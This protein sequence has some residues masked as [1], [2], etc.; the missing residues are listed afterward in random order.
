M[1]VETLR[2]VLCRRRL[3][4]VGRT[5][6]AQTLGVQLV[7]RRAFAVLHVAERPVY[8][9]GTRACGLAS[10]RRV[11]LLRR[12]GDC[13]VVERGLGNVL[14]FA[15]RRLGTGQFAVF[16]LREV[17]IRFAERFVLRTRSRRRARHQIYFSDKHVFLLRVVLE[18]R[19]VSIDVDSQVGCGHRLLGRRLYF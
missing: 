5:R 6:L 4:G 7:R 18:L 8:V 3:F 16:G 11:A 13:C 14:S 2:L 19:V 12:A 17:L 9:F 15:E 10:I 1:E